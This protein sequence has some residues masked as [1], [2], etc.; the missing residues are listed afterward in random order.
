M[1]RLPSGSTRVRRR[2]TTKYTRT[3]KVLPRKKKPNKFPLLPGDD[4][5]LGRPIFN[6]SDYPAARFAVFTT[7]MFHVYWM[8]LHA[9]SFLI[10]EYH[11]VGDR[12][13]IENVGQFFLK[14][15]SRGIFGCRECTEHYVEFANLS[16]LGQ[17]DGNLFGRLAHD[18]D[19]YL[20]ARWLNNLHNAVHR[21]R[22][23]QTE[24][25]PVKRGFVV[26][27]EV[28]FERVKQFYEQRVYSAPIPGACNPTLVEA[29][30]RSEFGIKIRE[31]MSCNEIARGV[32]KHTHDH[33]VSAIYMRF[34]PIVPH[35]F[36]R[37]HWHRLRRIHDPNMLSP[38][39]F[40]VKGVVAILLVGIFQTLLLQKTL[41]T[42]SA[43]KAQSASK[44]AA[45]ILLAVLHR[46]KAL[47]KGALSE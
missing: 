38:S 34:K 18:Q 3:S 15:P 10:P 28:P 20:L 6:D 21:G 30:L 17:P 14:L 39:K 36:Y 23:E 45:L 26:R 9:I 5:V 8:L 40:T 47:A 13:A 12:D 4:P 29:F 32:K 19:P 31:D 43:T 27:A 24:S 2:L 7:E 33:Y 35:G 11:K 1:Q 37:H 42:R 46:A 44:V 16:N 22:K 25:G 41:L